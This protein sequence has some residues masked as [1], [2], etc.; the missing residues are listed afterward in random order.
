VERFPAAAIV[1]GWF[2]EKNNI[3]QHAD[4]D[5]IRTVTKVINGGFNGLQSRTALLSTA[6][7]AIV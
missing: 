6:K 5:D 7:T 1:S 4:R 3:N 2:W